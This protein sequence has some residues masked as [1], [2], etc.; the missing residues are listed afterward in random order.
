[1][2]TLWGHSLGG[3]IANLAALQYI[4]KVKEN[5]KQTKVSLVTFGSP[6]V[7]NKVFAQIMNEVGFARQFRVIYGQDPVTGVPPKMIQGHE[8]VHSGTEIKFFEERFDKP[9]LGQTNQDNCQ[10]M[11]LQFFYNLYYNKSFYH[12]SGYRKLDAIKLWQCI[13]GQSPQ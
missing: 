2:Y 6:R 4:M 11:N 13:G 12:H 7:G 10:D 8:F 9:Y 3:A 5:N 1:M